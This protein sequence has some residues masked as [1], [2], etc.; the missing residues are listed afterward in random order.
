MKTG[1]TLGTGRPGVMLPSQPENEPGLSLEDLATLF[2]LSDGIATSDLSREVK[3]RVAAA[4]KALLRSSAEER[5]PTR[6]RL[7]G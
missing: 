4:R 7:G 6:S 3:R 2:A 5:L 1:T